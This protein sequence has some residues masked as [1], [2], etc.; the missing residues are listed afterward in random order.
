[1]CVSRGSDNNSQPARKS[2]NFNVFDIGS[3]RGHHVPVRH[4]VRTTAIFVMAT[5]LAWHGFVL[6]IP[7]NHAKHGVPQEELLCTASHPLSQTNHLHA[8][9]RHLS[10][11]PCIACLAGSTAIDATDS[12]LLERSADQG[13]AEIVAAS[14][15][16][17]RYRSHLPLH[18]GPPSLV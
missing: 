13:A 10:P 15:L 17:S 14:D 11:H 12:A 3:S 8:S 4:P 5:L 18:R 16:R 9:G 2:S 7:H 6:S 1:V